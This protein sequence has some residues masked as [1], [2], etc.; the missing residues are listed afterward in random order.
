MMSYSNTRVKV[1][2][3][4]DGCGHGINDSVTL[5]PVSGGVGDDDLKSTSSHEFIPNKIKFQKKDGGKLVGSSWYTFMG[6][7]NVRTIR[8]D[9][10]RLELATQF[11]KNG[12]EV[13]GVQ[14]H[15]IV[16]EEPIRIEKFKG[17][18]SLITVSAWRNGAGAATGGVGFML[19]SKAHGGISLI[20]PYGS[21]V[22]NIS[23][24]GNPRLT[25]IT[26]YS[27]TEAASTEEAEDFH[28]TLRQAIADVPAHHLLLV[29]GDMNARLGQE[30]AGDRRWYFHPRT[31][32]NGELLRDTAQECCMDITNT[33]FRKK[34]SKMWT[35][36]SDGTLRK[37]QLD[38]ILIRQKWRNSLK[39]TEAFNTF[40]SVGSDHRMVGCWVKLSFRSSKKPAR[41]EHYDYSTLR[42]NAALQSH[43]AV[44]VRNRFSCLTE[45]GDTVTERYQKFV[46][47]I[48]ASSEAL[49]PKKARRRRT[50]PS[51]DP[52]V[53]TA[54][55]DLFLAKDRYHQDPCEENREEVAR[56][57]DCLRTVYVEVEEEILKSKIRKVEEAADRCKNKESWNLVNEITGRTRASCGLIEGGST[58]ERVKSWEGHFSRLLGQPPVVPDPNISI[59]TIHSPLDI[60]DG[61]FTL[62]ELQEAKKQ[63][64]EGKAHGD[65]GIPP[66]I[67][68]RVDLDEI[69][70]EFCNKALGDGLI[71]EQWKHSNIV[72]VPKKGDLTKADNYRGI[73]LTSI[74]S[75]TL[76]RMLL[77]R[78]KP[79]LE[80][81]L[82]NNQNGFRPGRSTTSH[83]LALRRIIEGAK[84][85]N[86]KATMV[87]I[88]F[89]KAFDSIHR[90]LLM[91]ILL[92]Y[93]IPKALVSLI[94]KLYTG[95]KA[96]VVTADG[97]T[98][99][100]DILA[101][102]LQGDTL[103][104]YLFIIVIDYIMTVTMEEFDSEPGFTIR[105]ARS[106]RVGAEKL[107]DLEFADDVALCSDTIEEAQVLLE[108]LEAAAN[109]VGLN[110]NTSKTKFMT[111]NGEE[112]DKLTNST[113]S[114]IEQVSDFIYL[115]SWVAASDKDF[116][117]RK[118]KTWAA[119]HKMKK[120]WSSGMRRNLKVR[121]F[122]AT[123]ESILL[124]G[125]E[126]WTLT[127]SMK[128]RVDGCYTRMLRMALNI[129]W[130]WGL[131][132]REVYGSLP[133]VTMKIQE[134]RMRLAG[135]IHRH[136]ELAAHQVLLWEPSHGNRSRG[137]P[138]FTYVDC[139]RKDTGLQ[140]VKEIGGLMAD[141]LLWRQRI[142][143]RTLKPP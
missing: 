49:L 59:R 97:I 85:K 51:S 63:I 99:L 74:V 10:K 41:R 62:A 43:F 72:P 70:L 42:T 75:K 84:A 44:E 13:L 1:P 102:V 21:R 139:L 135:H 78:I 81:V 88:D 54:R 18:V 103:A 61:P 83:I 96:R 65:D 89:K 92:A 104:P 32:R 57:K 8:E 66:E 110:M 116:E 90:G 11:L 115:G 26:A 4:H 58:E 71:P 129:D 105:P 48:G 76:N 35:H 19:S 87:F 142:D 137:R 25:A 27:P 2:K 33:R 20:K 132:N 122:I 73:S 134:R 5:K 56:R 9:Y 106:R 109:T 31:N 16:H 45:E 55:S 118:A 140:D 67:L 60:E 101:G 53:D 40:Q 30:S 136:P 37:G 91:K 112:S 121:L 114:E 95:T 36:L 128:K 15:R 126:T 138:A 64:V 133:R 7:F 3:L 125:S 86:L 141:R 28:N 93:G 124:Y 39:N 120:V 6:T 77:N 38:F 29:L 17:G 100:F 130:R 94:E 127:E 80:E 47:S 111:V 107:A 68:K 123:V 79:R 50:D 23:F 117:V 98:D 24:N 14:E 113:G 52:R 108:R 22:L 143:T 82:R 69:I 12:V 34:E 119:C 131:T 46:E